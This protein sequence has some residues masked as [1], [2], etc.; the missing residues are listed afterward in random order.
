MEATSTFDGFHAGPLSRS[1]WN[2]EMLVFVR[3]ENQRTRRKILGARREPTRNST[4]I[5]HRVG[6]EPGPHGW[7]AS[8]LTT[9]PSLLPSKSVCATRMENKECKYQSLLYGVSHMDWE[10]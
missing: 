3:E 4:H 6:I 1:N 7:E 9:A 2:L 8:T 10:L 5:R